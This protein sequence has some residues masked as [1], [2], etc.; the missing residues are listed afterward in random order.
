MENFEGEH[1]HLIQLDKTKIDHRYVYR[2]TKRMAD[3]LFSVGGIIAL[4]PLFV[5][6]AVAIKLEEP[7]GTILYKQERLGR[8]GRKF[9]IYKFRSMCMDAD[10]KLAQLKKYNEVGGAMFKMKHDPRVTRVGRLI[11]KFSLDELPQLF[12]VLRGEMSLVGPR[13]PLPHEVE[14]YSE[15]DKQRLYVIPGCTGLWQVSARNEVGFEEM[16]ELDLKYIQKSNLLYDFTLILKT[17]KIMVLPN[18]AY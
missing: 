17:V 18:G 16:V 11:R 5:L 14:Q 7:S 9:L 4:S 6:L 2:V 3:I 15:Y 1:G 12:N 10:Q 13:P 8:R